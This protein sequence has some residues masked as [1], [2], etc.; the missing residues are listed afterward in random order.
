MTVAVG[1]TK[2]LQEVTGFIGRW[3][4]VPPAG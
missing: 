3:S 2:P 4:A 1:H